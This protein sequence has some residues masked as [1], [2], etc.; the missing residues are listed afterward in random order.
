MSS[1]PQNP[2]IF[3]RQRTSYWQLLWSVINC[4]FG[5]TKSILTYTIRL[6]VC[7]LQPADIEGQSHTFRAKIFRKARPCDL[8]Q[9]P[10]TEQGSC[11][12]VCKYACHR[13]CEIKVIAACEPVVN[14]ELQSHEGVKLSHPRRSRSPG[15]HSLERTRGP[16]IYERPTSFIMDIMYVTER[17]IAITFPEMG[18]NA[19]YK[20]NL[21][22]VAHML[23]TKHGTRYMV[24]NLSERRHDLIKLNPQVLD[25]GWPQYLAPP[26]ERLCSI[27]KSLDSW[28]SQDPQ[29]IAVLHSKGD[30]GRTGIVI[31]AYMH[32]SNICASA[33]QALDRFAMKRF[34]DDKLSRAMHPSQKRYIHYF[35]GLLSGAIR[36][37]NSTLYLHHIIIHGVPNFDS[38]GGCRPFVKIY[39]GMHPIYTSGV[40]IVTERSRRIIITVEPSIQ[41]R[42][43]ILVKCYHKKQRPAGRSVIFRVQFHTCTLDSDR[44][45]F[46]KEELDD[47]A[48]DAR[49][50]EDGKVELQFSY[51]Q[52]DYKGNGSIHDAMVPVDN[53]YDPLVRSDSYEAF[54]LAPED[55]IEGSEE[56]LETDREQVHHTEGPLDGSLYATVIKKKPLIITSSSSSSSPPNNQDNL[57]DADGPH[58]SMDS[59][60]SSASGIQ[61]TAHSP[62]L[63]TKQVQVNGNITQTSGII[64]VEVSHKTEVTVGQPNMSPPKEECKQ[65]DELLNGMLQEIQSIPDL[66]PHSLPITYLPVSKSS[67]EHSTQDKPYNETK[68]QLTQQ[69]VPSNVQNVSSS[70]ISVKEPKQI[71]TSN[72]S[73]DVS[74]TSDSKD[75]KKM[76]FSTNSSSHPSEN[77]HIMPLAHSQEH[78][79]GSFKECIFDDHR[80]RS[81]EGSSMSWLEKQQQKLKTRKENKELDRYQLEQMVIA[82]L[83]MK[84]PRSAPHNI[85]SNKHMLDER[86][87]QSFPPKEYA[88]N[89][90]LSFATPLHIITQNNL[91]MPQPDSFISSPYAE[92]NLYNHSGDAPSS[93]IIPSRSSSKD[94][95]RARYQEWQ[96]QNRILVRHRSDT[97]YDRDRPSFSKNI[98]TKDFK[99]CRELEPLTLEYRSMYQFVPQQSH[100]QNNLSH[101]DQSNIGE[102][103][104]DNIDAQQSGDSRDSHG[105]LTLSHEPNSSSQLH[106]TDQSAISPGLS[107]YRLEELQQSLLAM[108]APSYPP[109]QPPQPYAQSTPNQCVN[110][111]GGNVPVWSPSFVCSSPSSSP[112]RNG[113]RPLTPAFPLQPLTPYINRESP[114]VPPRN[115][116]QPSRHSLPHQLSLLPSD[117]LGLLKRWFSSSGLNFHRKE[118]H[119][120]SSDNIPQW[121]QPTYNINGQS[122]PTVYCGQ[123]HRSSMVSLA[124]SPEVI[125]QHPMFVRDTSKFW[126]K[127]SITR[128]E[129]IALLKDKPPGTFIVRDSNSFPGAFGLALKVATPPPNVQ[130]TGDISNELVRHF[131]IEPSSKGVRLKGN[132]F[133]PIFGSLS[134][135]VYQHTIT[136]LAL[137]C[138]LVL[139]EYDFTEQLEES[140]TE[141]PSPS[142]SLITQGAACNVVFLGSADTESLTGPQAVRKALSHLFS[143]RT[144]PVLTLVHFKVSSH[145]ITLTDIKHKLFF[146]RHYSVTTVSYCGLDPDGRRWNQGDKEI[147]IP[148]ESGRCFGF[149]AR[150]PV[151]QTENQCHLFA[152]WELDQP[153]SAIVSFVNKV[154]VRKFLHGNANAV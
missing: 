97:S 116:P 98:Q 50:S 11:C 133:E 49:F 15:S 3:I 33:D 23:K 44:L 109:P 140:Q 106:S 87:N 112:T 12:R 8:C 78:T 56:I 28:L 1:Q 124:E 51:H 125:H 72:K 132:P 85:V 31:A 6:W 67:H 79:T 20:S 35:A 127:P 82:E 139:P 102:M 153:A 70:V 148:L 74:F 150:S 80:S 154:I 52:G 63:A 138:K 147:S 39:Q 113:D 128:E 118:H 110:D 27:C 143:K 43:D 54:D 149:V 101:R 93:P 152:E 119:S 57:S 30:K 46:L 144:L 62:P 135:L 84:Q 22:E 142:N 16:R 99:K 47:A 81:P 120:P 18:S 21:K 10:I 64:Q 126:Y 100:L 123:S 96:N 61:V 111:G 122:S 103:P 60:I 69:L 58:L 42:G 130:P 66:P 24:F 2:P 14:Y 108:S 59:G 29:H 107:S 13:K 17:I 7:N 83:Q 55:H 65:L 86:I 151:K 146:R 5:W 104:A 38:K 121:Q 68:S 73:H 34:Y 141:S 71:D 26:L 89:K 25:F 131:L 117:R 53:S 90:V 36:M 19:L 76:E 129:A 91:M 145:G 95:T 41:L 134:A 136:P 75:S 32:Y 88:S 115:Q 40:Y 77:L 4:L 137:P 105:L 45:V 37:N 92:Q 48:F 114:P 94:V 9:Q